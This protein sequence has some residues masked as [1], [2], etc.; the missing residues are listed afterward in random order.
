MYS[1]CILRSVCQF[2]LGV[3]IVGCVKS[4]E[5]RSDLQRGARY[6]AAN[7]RPFLVT[8][9]FYLASIRTPLV[10][11][12]TEPLCVVVIQAVRHTIE[13]LQMRFQLSQARGLDRT[14]LGGFVVGQYSGEVA[15]FDFL[16]D[17][18][19]KGDEGSRDRRRS[20]TSG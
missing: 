6:S 1:G 7:G 10:L 13:T 20:V 11:L 18:N 12:C 15:S 17:E 14:V 9:A 2:Q 4:G 8:H 3:V 5:G 16:L 19:R